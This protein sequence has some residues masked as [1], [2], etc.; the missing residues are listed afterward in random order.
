MHSR[1]LA[2]QGS[3]RTGRSWRKFGVNSF[4][5]EIRIDDELHGLGSEGYIGL[6]SLFQNAERVVTH[7]QILREL[8]GETHTKDTHYVRILVSKLRVKVQDDAVESR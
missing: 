7:P 2:R 4:V 5:R 1:T 8:W 6:A 3:I